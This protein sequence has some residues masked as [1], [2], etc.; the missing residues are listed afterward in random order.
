[1]SA[2]L[3]TPVA[4]IG[5]GAWGTALAW[6]LADKEERVRLWAFEA[7]AVIAIATAR[8]NRSYLPGVRLPESLEATNFLPD[9]VQGAEALIFA[10]P[11][12]VAAGV[13]AQLASLLPP[14]VPIVSAT[15][16][17]EQ[18]KLR[19]TSALL[20][21]MLP[22]HRGPVFALS[23]PSFAVEVCRR[24]PTAV[25]LAGPPGPQAR[26]LQRLL[27]TPTFRVYLSEDR[28]GVELGGALKNVIALA[29][30]V[31][32]GLGFGHNTRAALITRGLAEMVR[33]GVAMGADARTFAGL[34][35]MGDLVLTCTGSLSRNREVGIRLGQGKKL[36]DILAGARTVAEG[37]NTARAAKA[38]AE[39]HHVEMPIVQEVC[40]VLF[41]GKDPR[42][43]VTDLMERAARPELD[44]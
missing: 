34:S 23:G 22:A 13:L 18:E 8:E 14:G 9:A 29:A 41:D 15:K 1:M 36:A 38:L 37:V 42:R 43:A 3:A 28:V 40:A 25:V 39:R 12:H 31:V 19:L 16:G 6:L 33:L 32:D 35:G 2:P 27:M 26:A 11:S 7:E 5:G 20:E 24:Q 21:E 4:V 44:Q 10:V 30:G 17:I